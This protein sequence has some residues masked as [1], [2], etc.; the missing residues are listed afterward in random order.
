[1]GGNGWSRDGQKGEGSG[2]GDPEHSTWGHTISI[3]DSCSAAVAYRARPPL[4]LLGYNI[5][6]FYALIER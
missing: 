4:T 3:S 5:L 6:L 2:G 1:M